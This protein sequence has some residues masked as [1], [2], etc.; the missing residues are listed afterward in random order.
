MRFG[1]PI[2]TR[3]SPGALDTIR[4]L[5]QAAGRDPKAI[6]LS[7]R[8]PLRFTDGGGAGSG[9][10]F[11]GSRDQ[12]VEDILTYQ[13]PGVSRL[14]FDFGGPSVEAVLEQLQ[15]FAEE[16]RPAVRGRP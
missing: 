2:P 1:F 9:T 13:R 12:M 16:V 5:A 6:T 10:P 11:I 7:F 3:G 8:A 4:R 15:R 14:I